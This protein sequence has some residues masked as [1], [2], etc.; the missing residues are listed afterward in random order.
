MWLI[1]APFQVWL[2]AGRP[3]EPAAT[4]GSSS[5]SP[6]SPLSKISW[7]WASA[8]AYFML[9][10]GTSLLV[11]AAMACD[12]LQRGDKMEDAPGT[13]AALFTVFS[14]QSNQ[15][16][17]TDRFTDRTGS[18]YCS[19]SN[20]TVSDWEVEQAGRFVWLYFGSWSDVCAI[21]RD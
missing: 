1:F 9:R 14:M 12:Q 6:H 7:K 8:K 3:N 16:L 4:W 5:H 2:T 20:Q 15:Q 13:W 18:V 11:T 17:A 19:I 21:I 10:D